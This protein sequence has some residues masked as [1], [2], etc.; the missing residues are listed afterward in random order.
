VTRFTMGN[1]SLRVRVALRCAVALLGA[2]CTVPAAR[3]QVLDCRTVE[4]SRR[5]VCNLNV[6]TALGRSDRISGD[7]T[8]HTA[9]D[10]LLHKEELLRSFLYDEKCVSSP[11]QQAESVASPPKKTGFWE[12]FIRV[13]KAWTR[14]LQDPPPFSSKLYADTGATCSAFPERAAK[15]RCEEEKR[16]A[17]ETKK[18]LR[19]R[20]NGWQGFSDNG[21][22]GVSFDIIRVTGSHV[23]ACSDQGMVNGTIEPDGSLVF[24]R[25]GTLD[26]DYRFK[27][28]RVAD[29]EE[30]RGAALLALER[31]RDIVAGPVWLSK[32]LEPA[33]AE[34]VPDSCD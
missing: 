14:L 33:D 3:A 1:V 29:A 26:V 5:D 15:K 18:L 2:G 20:W 24:P 12:Q 28:W 6:L 17:D 32:K 23:K 31:A 19:G 11:P 7:D 16:V 8:R 10:I 13:S 22:T 34:L 21:A 30:L 25:V 4:C 9:V 27:L